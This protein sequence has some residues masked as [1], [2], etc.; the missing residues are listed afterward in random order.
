MQ[1]HR[2]ISA[3]VHAQAL[4][5]SFSYS[6]AASAVYWGLAQPAWLRSLLACSLTKMP[7]LEAWSR[8]VV[9]ETKLALR[10]PSHLEL[11][12]NDVAGT[13]A[14][15]ATNKMLCK[16]C[17]WTA[18]MK[19]QC[20]AVWAEAKSPGPPQKL[21]DVCNYCLT[22]FP[23]QATSQLPKVGLFQFQCNLRYKEFTYNRLNCTV[24]VWQA[25]L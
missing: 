8:Q 23:R 16:T 9:T 2:H 15:C 21:H 6:G 12:S 3:Q 14:G 20:S 19:A 17:L 5:S 10:I 24:M 4:L 18:S 7:H 13:G 1:F 22:L 25:Y 11:E